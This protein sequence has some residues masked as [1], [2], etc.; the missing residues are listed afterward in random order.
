MSIAGSGFSKTARKVLSI[1]AAVPL[2]LA[3]MVFAPSASAAA[4]TMNPIDCIIPKLILSKGDDATQL[5]V[6]AYNFSTAAATKGTR[7]TAMGS[8]WE[9]NGFTR[10]YNAIAYNRSDGFIYALASR[11]LGGVDLL[12]IGDKGVVSIVG[13]VQ[14]LPTELAFWNNGS[15]VNGKYYVA[16]DR[17]DAFYQIDLGTL[18][19]VTIQLSQKWLPAD[20]VQINGYLW[21]I[22][23]QTMYRMYPGTGQVST[24]DIGDLIGGR[25]YGAGG[26]VFRYTNGDFGVVSSKIGVE[27]QIHIENPASDTPTFTKVAA[28]DSPTS[29]QI[30]GTSCTD[31]HFGNSGL[32][33]RALWVSQSM[34]VAEPGTVL[35]F[36]FSLFNDSTVYMRDISVIPTVH[37]PYGGTP[38]GTLSQPTCDSIGLH[39]GAMSTCTVTYTMGEWDPEYGRMTISGAAV[40]YFN[41]MT[42]KSEVVSATAY[43]MVS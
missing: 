5:M 7:F 13:A 18:N 39:P 34:L 26:A 42:V 28:V 22:F 38:D 6:K 37:L 24:F 23:E 19:A 20:S 32:T 36:Q 25:I 1:A 33:A 14:G 29:T 41:D 11:D 15:F 8:P 35:T 2:A 31:T 9:G 43:W 21:G 40:A 16:K 30:D 27:T 4:P 12:K 10:T 17:G 3:G